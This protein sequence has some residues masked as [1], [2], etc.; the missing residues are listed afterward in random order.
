M[1][2]DVENIRRAFPILNQEIN[3]KALVYLD[4]GAT[5]QKPDVVVQSLVD[6][7][8]KTNSNVHRGAHRLSQLATEQYEGARS[9]IASYINAAQAREVIFTRGTSESVNLVANSFDGF[10]D[11]GD[12]VL[13]T[14]L[15]HHSNIVP[16]QQLCERTGASLQVVALDE[17]GDLD[18]QDLQAKL[19]EKTKLLALAH[20]SNV[21]GS[22][23]PIKQIVGM[24][25]ARDIPV[26]VDG[27]Q[28]IAHTHVDVQDMDCDFYA[29]SGHKTYG[30]M[31]IG[32]LYGKEDW[33]NKLP[34][35]QFGGEMIAHVSFEKTSFTTL[36]YK[37]EA[38]TPNV[39][40]ALGLEA[41]IR[42]I[43][44]IG[45]EPIIAHEDNLL[46]YATDQ[47]EK[48]EGLQVVGKAAHKTAVLSFVV[49]G[50]HA[51]DIGTLLDQMGVAIRTGNHCAQPLID[52]LGYHGVVRAT[53][54]L[55]NTKSE[56]D[57]MAEAVNKAVNMLR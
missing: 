20:I 36:P 50:I 33:L 39:S 10:V 54:G 11:A 34:P 35:Y 25:H 45:M 56:M 57:V 15:E 4:N 52:K 1:A 31:G 22:I 18:L 43:E 29:F 5:T 13:I 51:S 8:H 48:I 40:G 7:Y 53:I 55:Y 47:L 27:A 9:Y 2:F 26:F 42:F 24:A 38:G 32:V 46:E 12:Q 14:T 49:E 21:L 16:W 23:N 28:A 37:F 44:E 19:S 6:Y 17:N 3:G 41:A 30:P